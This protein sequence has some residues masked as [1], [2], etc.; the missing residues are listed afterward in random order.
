MPFYVGVLA[1]IHTRLM[2]VH[3]HWRLQPSNCAVL[4]SMPLRQ[5]S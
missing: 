3:V 5:H 1:T 2:L 4:R